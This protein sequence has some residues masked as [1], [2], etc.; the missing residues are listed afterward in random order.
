MQARPRVPHGGQRSDYAVARISVE[1]LLAVCLRAGCLRGP[2]VGETKLA[3]GTLT[4][5]ENFHN[6]LKS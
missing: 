3:A 2:E 6:R 5:C 1:L 4:R